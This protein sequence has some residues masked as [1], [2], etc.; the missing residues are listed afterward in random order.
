MVLLLSDPRVSA[1]PVRENG[2][3]IVLV[4]AFLGRAA[5]G[6]AAAPVPVRRELAI[7][8]ERA[9]ATLP[10]GVVL[11]V[12]EGHRSAESQRAIIDDYSREL[13]RGQPDLDTATLTTLTSRF[14]SPLDVA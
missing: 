7:R 12:V 6:L 13:R 14:V 10:P 2:D 11:K 5:T 1:V 8:L 9:A 4:R 3:P